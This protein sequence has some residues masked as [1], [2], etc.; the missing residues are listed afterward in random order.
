MMGY[1]NDKP[2]DGQPDRQ[3]F[4]NIKQFQKDTGLPVTGKLDPDT[5][6]M[7]ERK[8]AEGWKRTEQ[9]K[10]EHGVYIS[11]GQ[12][13]QLFKESGHVLANK[14]TDEMVNSLNRALDKYNI[15][16]PKEIKLFITVCLHESK[17]SLTEAGWCSK[18]YVKEYCKMYEPGTAKGKE[19]GN[20]QVGDGYLFRGGGFIQITGRTNYQAFA[21]SIGDPEIMKKGADYVA[22][23][24]PW[25]AAAFWWKENKI[26]N[27]IAKGSNQDD[28]TTFKQVSNAVN[29][30]PAKAYVKGFPNNWEDRV[31]KFKIVNKI[32]KD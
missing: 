11:K 6:Y 21:D 15:T 17:L 14:I 3:T 5:Y 7:L 23:K 31:D 27:I 28:L 12:L 19:L 25:E 24:Y 20:I 4:E 16:N 10:L 29:K 8:T 1:K 32:I 13:E 18:N 30:G 22:Q 2:I 26:S 9:F